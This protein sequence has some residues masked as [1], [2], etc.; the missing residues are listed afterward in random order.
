MKNRICVC[1][2]VLL[3]SAVFSCEPGPAVDVLDFDDNTILHTKWPFLVGAAV[4]G[5][6]TSNADMSSSQ[7]N[8]LNSGNPQHPLLKHFNVVAAE[9]EM[10]PFAIMPSSQPSGNN[11][12]NSYVWT[13]SDALVNYAKAN[14]KRVR[15]HCLIW[16]DQ[17]PS[18]FFGGSIDA[19]YTRM[20]NH[21]KAV[22]EKYGDTIEWWDVVNEAIDHDVAGPRVNS[23]Y[24][25]IMEAA[26]KKGM[27]RYDYILKAFQWAR[28]YADQYGEP[29]KVKL[30][31]TDYGV[32]RPFT[33]GGTTK[34]D[35]FKALVEWL[36]QND[37]PIDGVGFQ[38]HFRLYDHPVDKSKCLTCNGNPS[39]NHDISS[40]IDLF[41]AIK[42][43]DG[44][45]IMVQICELD[46]SIFSNA[47]NE[48]NNTKVSDS[49][50]NERLSDLA[51]TYRDY[52]DM[53]KEKY[54]EGKLDMVVLW[55]IADGHSWLNDHPVK[56][57]TDYPLL[58][59]RNYKGKEAYK[60]L[61]E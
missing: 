48:A 54:D 43:K 20:E 26:G 58:F 50:L 30:Y 27:D 15:G 42:K 41:S 12:V 25:K 10:K 31:L 11:W 9:N 57:R 3:I 23:G 55:G 19:L 35:D 56:G 14:S 59:N 16:H 22:F 18:W 29:G 60:K 33:R 37:A 6:R 8:A 17:T 7:A 4:P 28:K 52:F 38:G 1:L 46:I 49:V 2:I 53:F 39:C 51:Q 5:A 34:Q 47:K 36:I 44:T 24:T 40:G 21:I 61:T 32:E 45:N 13:D